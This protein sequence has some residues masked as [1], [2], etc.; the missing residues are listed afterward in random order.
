MANIPRRGD[1]DRATRVT[2]TIDRVD[3]GVGAAR[4]RA[5]RRGARASVFPRS[6][7]RRCRAFGG[8]SR[9]RSPGRAVIG[10]GDGTAS[11]THL[12]PVSLVADGKVELVLPVALLLLLLLRGGCLLLVRLLLVRLL[13]VLHLLR[14]HPVRGERRGGARS[15]RDSRAPAGGKDRATIAWAR[16][17]VG[18]A[19]GRAA[20]AAACTG[21]GTAS[22]A[23]SE[24]GACRSPDG[25]GSPASL[26]LLRARLRGECVASSRG[27]PRSTRI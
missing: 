7:L 26:R 5:S 23:P 19:R 10:E 6:R 3:R 9:A 24:G 4:S 2:R 1:A 27:V 14:V 21:W 20:A 13:L 15:A 16:T 8:R 22:A 18:T 11:R 17:V 12:G 25:E